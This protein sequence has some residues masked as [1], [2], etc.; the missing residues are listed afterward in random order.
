M[1]GALQTA[2]ANL[3]SFGIGAPYWIGKITNSNETGTGIASDSSGNVYVSGAVGTTGGT[4]YGL[5]LI[6]YNL[7]GVVQWQRTVTYPAVSQYGGASRVAVDSSGNVYVTF[8]FSYSSPSPRGAIIKYDS[9]GNLQFKK[10]FNTGT[11]RLN[12][13]AVDSSGNFYLHG[14]GNNNYNLTTSKFNSSGTFQ[15]N[16]NIFTNTG[17][18]A[19]GISVDSSGNTYAAIEDNPGASY[20][21]AAIVKRDISGAV[22][23]ANKLYVA[24]YYCGAYGT[25]VDSAGNSYVCGYARQGATNRYDALLAQYDLSGVLQWQRVLYNTNG[26]TATGVAVDSSNNVYVSGRSNGSSNSPAFIAKYNSSGTIQWQR[27]ILVFT[28]ESTYLSVDLS[29]N[30]Y[31]ISYSSTNGGAP[32]DAWVFKFKN[33]G[34]GTGTYTVGGTTVT[35][36]ASSLTATTSSLTQGAVSYTQPG[37]TFTEADAPFIDAAGSMTSTVVTI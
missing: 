17:N 13:L 30:I 25:A 29:G 16:S 6:K 22:I 2:L 37:V 23:W 32:F 19:W 7:S 21:A 3:R 26:A 8:Q 4:N 24:S 12:G 15:W 35:Y 34:S 28:M 33:D 5:Y 11:Y 36:A 10:F 31:L 27:T 18:D 9:S 20:Y 1:S 14:N